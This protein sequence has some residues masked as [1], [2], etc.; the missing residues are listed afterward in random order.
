MEIAGEL[1]Q[2]ANNSSIFFVSK[3]H[4]KSLMGKVPIKRF[5]TDYV[6]KVIIPSIYEI[7]KNAQLPKNKYKAFYGLVIGSLFKLSTC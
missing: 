5:M 7:I 6:N 2:I 1:E 4:I 3:I